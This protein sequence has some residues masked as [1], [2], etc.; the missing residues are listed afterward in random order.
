MS[1]KIK[2]AVVGIGNCFAGLYQGIEYYK[3]HPERKVTGIMHQEMAGYTIHDIE[4]VSAF[5]IAKKKVNQT[6]DK[7][8]YAEPNL[9]NWVKLKESNVIVKPS[10][11]LDGVGIYVKDLI[12]PINGRPIDQIR[13]EILEEL[14]QSGAEMIVSYLPVGSQKAT[15]FWANVALEA[16]VG[17][18]NCIPVFIGSDQEW[19]KKFR[20]KNI[21]LIGDDIKSQVG[22][23]IV[24]RV[25]AKLFMDRGVELESTYQLNVGGNTDFKN[26][27]ERNRLESKEKSKTNSV[28]SQLKVPL[29]KGKIHIGPSDYV[30]FLG[31]T[32]I[33][34]MR[35]NGREWGDR[36][37]NVEIR[38]QVND[39]AN[40]GGIVIDAIRAVKIALDRGIGGSLYSA[41]AY[42]MKSPPKQMS[43]DDARKA[44]EDFIHR[45]R[46]N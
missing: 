41:S 10:P 42:L 11:V 45:K 1:G 6:L 34:F 44:L 30:E 4:F 3:Q 13:K 9:V 18:V 15:E 24:H 32:K 20:D 43:D 21:P 16:G 5:D 38:L 12:Q 33:A 36:P 22:A 28:Q 35:L 40:S 25:L 7:A 29:P 39:K 27:L 46:D 8:I 31:N 19:I 26:M 2:V 14:S 23:T 17:F 37:M